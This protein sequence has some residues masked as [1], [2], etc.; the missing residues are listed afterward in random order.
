MPIRSTLT[1]FTNFLLLCEQNPLGEA[2][3]SSEEEARSERG[4]PHCFQ[5]PGR[6]RQKQ[7]KGRQR[8]AWVP[9]SHPS[10]YT[11]FDWACHL[12]GHQKQEKEK[13]CGQSY[14]EP[15][16]HCELWTIKLGS[17]Q[18]EKLAVLV[19]SCQVKSMYVK[20]YETK[21]KL[22]AWWQQSEIRAQIRSL[23]A[24]L[25]M[26]P[27][28]SSKYCTPPASLF[29][30]FLF[31]CL[32]CFLAKGGLQGSCSGMWIGKEGL[33]RLISDPRAYLKDGI[34]GLESL[35]RSRTFHTN[36]SDPLLAGGPLQSNF[37][38]DRWG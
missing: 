2:E 10:T 3:Y 24:F 27:L 16:D 31:V 18:T 8:M 17:G 11:W 9:N 29:W 30:D 34:G 33:I 20:V 22:H 37:F 35:G 15:D 38:I 5:P 32:L 14:N 21:R 1:Y 25:I 6:N 13:T 4:K 28:C 19:V 12:V 36:L 26:V 23:N 7:A